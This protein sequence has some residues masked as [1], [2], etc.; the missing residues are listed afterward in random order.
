MVRHTSPRNLLVL[1]TRYLP[2]GLLALLM[3]V[4]A[5]SGGAS[6][7]PSASVA[8]S[9]EA[10]VE[11]SAAAE[12]AEATSS[13]A[14]SEA[15][16]G[17][18]ADLIPDDLNGVAPQITNA[19]DNPMMAQALAAAGVE[20]TDFEYLIAT[21]GTD[22]DAVTLSAMRIPGVDGS[23]L[24]TLAQQM[25]GAAAG[26]ELET[27]SVGGKSVLQIT[28]SGTPGSAYL[29]ITGGTVFTVIGTDA[30]QVGQL[31]AELP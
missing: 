18:L 4:T 14:A 1:R 25:S 9:S 13:E 27:T 21:Y 16:S 30:D 15:P 5:C 17:P 10:A 29:Y 23:T 26:G 19:G 7:T 8:A 2:A 3:V 11:S 24:E 6:T 12:T 22:A 31:L 28:G 20:A